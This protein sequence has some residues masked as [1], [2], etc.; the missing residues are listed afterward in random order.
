MWKYF[1]FAAPLRIYANLDRCQILDFSMAAS[2]VLLA[3]KRRRSSFFLVREQPV[4][5]CCFQL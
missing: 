3:F 4:L 5:L 1:V 2:S